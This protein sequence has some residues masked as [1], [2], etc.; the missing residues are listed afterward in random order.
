MMDR[1]ETQDFVTAVYLTCCGFRPELRQVRPGR[2]EFV[3]GAS[4]EL[5][6]ALRPFRRGE[7]RVSPGAFHLCQIELRRGM[8]R[9]LS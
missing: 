4:E 2:I 8:D 7:A 5:E 1:F 6:D 9:V 3:F